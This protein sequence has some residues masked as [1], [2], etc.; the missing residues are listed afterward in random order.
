[1]ATSAML[2]GGSKLYLGD[3]GIGAGTQ[4]SKVFGTSN[5]KLKILYKEAGVIGNTKTAGVVVSGNNT[6]YSQT[7]SPTAILINASTDGSGNS[8]TTVAEAISALYLNDTFKTYWEAT[9]DDGDGSG[10]I[11]AGASGVLSGGV[12]GAEVFTELAECKDVTGPAFTSATVDAT[13]FGTELGTRDYIIG[14]ADPG[15][16]SFTLNFLPGNSQHLS[17]RTLQQNNTARNFK[18]VWPDGK[19]ALMNGRVSNFSISTPTDGIISASVSIKLS[20][21]VTFG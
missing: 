6:A 16:L 13:H 17:L 4:A 8:T 20:G 18:L 3:G 10:V 19:Y 21:A 1:M 12:D 7:I 2:G 9:V 5:Q 14:R 11:V 15:E